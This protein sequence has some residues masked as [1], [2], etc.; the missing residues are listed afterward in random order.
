MRLSS[1]TQ[2]LIVDGIGGAVLLTLAVFAF[3]GFDQSWDALEYHLP[4]AALRTGILTSRDLVLQSGL[5]FRYNGFPAL[6]DIVQGGLWRLFGTP[7]A[8]ALVTPLAMAGFAVYVRCAF[9]IGLLWPVMIFIAV[10]TLHTA[11]N[12]AYVDLW[13][14]AF[15]ALHL[16]AAFKTLQPGERHR[17]A[18]LIISL[19]ALGVAVNAKE[20]YYVLGGLSLGLYGLLLMAGWK[21]ER[22]RVLL[23]I[24][25]LAPVAFAAPLKNLIVYG[26]PIYPMAFAALDWEGPE[27]AYFSPS[28]ST[29]KAPRPVRYLLSQMELDALDEHKRG[30][31]LDQGEAEGKLGYHMG[32]SSEILLFVTVVTLILC[33]RRVHLSRLQKAEMGS[34]AILVAVV[35]CFPG[36]IE[37]RYF[38]FVEIS[39]ILADLCLLKHLAHRHDAYSEGLS[40]GFYATLMGSALFVGF[41]T[42][43]AHLTPHPISFERMIARRKTINPELQQAR[44]QSDTICYVRWDP[45]AILYVDIFHPDLPPYR[46]VEVLHRD[47]CPAGSAIIDVPQKPPVDP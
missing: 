14:N 32:G 22:L 11:L 43:F 34:F 31:S 1:R 6:I 35:S 40:A 33:L 9:R 16:A 20:Q 44:A 25:V 5:Q 30:Y 21:A 3:L 17:K 4:Y 2:L 19:L 15:F 36:S 37:L 27:K 23:V 24:A 8:A 46:V 18:H 47:E 10:P 38:S 45:D 29:G 41:L 12:A 39:L 13:T 26:N 7:K 42:G 28:P